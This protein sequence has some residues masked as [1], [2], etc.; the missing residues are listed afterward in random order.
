MNNGYG[1]VGTNTFLGHHHGNGF[2]DYIGTSH[3]NKLCPACLR[4]GTD[5]HLLDTGRGTG[6]ESGFIAADHQTAYIRGMECIHVLV[7]IDGINHLFFVNML[8][9]RQLNQNAVDIRVIVVFTDQ[10]QQIRFG[11]IFGLIILNFIKS[12]RQRCFYLQG[13]IAD[14]RRVVAHKDGC[15]TGYFAV[16]GLYLFNVFFDFSQN[17]LSYLG[18]ANNFCG[19]PISPDMVRQRRKNRTAPFP[20][21]DWLNFD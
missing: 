16:F 7:R 11:D 15:Q 4:V 8:G 10:S 2:A 12:N 1:S 21:P 17:S 19:H 14:R 3:H 20:F 18:S 13:Y 6:Q 9:Q 5:N